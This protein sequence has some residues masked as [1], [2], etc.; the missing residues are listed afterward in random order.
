VAVLVD[1][2]E[3][4]LLDLEATL[5]R[6]GRAVD[7]RIEPVLREEK[8]DPSGLTA[9]ILRTGYVVYSAA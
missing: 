1:R 7:F 4:D 9:E 5:F 3:G 8:C 6:L 2:I